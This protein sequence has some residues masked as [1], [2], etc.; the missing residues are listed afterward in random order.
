MRLDVMPG[1]L[2][3]AESAALADGL[4]IAVAL[5]DQEAERPLFGVLLPGMD[6]RLDLAVASQGFLFGGGLEGPLE[7]DDLQDVVG[8]RLGFLG[9]ESPHDEAAVP[10]GRGGEG[11]ADV[12]PTGLAHDRGDLAPA[13]V[14][15]KALLQ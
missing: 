9:I 12:G 6:Q 1:R 4:L 7:V 15:I 3:L 11:D 8:P 5:D 10:G 2:E 13:P 14:E